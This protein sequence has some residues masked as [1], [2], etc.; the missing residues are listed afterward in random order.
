[1][2][3]LCGRFNGFALTGPLHL[4][5][6]STHKEFV[7]ALEA[8]GLYD[9]SALEARDWTEMF[10]L[11]S[12]KEI[13]HTPDKIELMGFMI[14]RESLDVEGDFFDGISLTGP[15]HLKVNS[16]REE[17]IEALKKSGLYDETRRSVGR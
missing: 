12:G 2:K 15:L 1:M 10:T 8:S 6:N 5:V 7:K 11:K 13:L 3:A 4:K 9:A 16:T 14:V 17:F